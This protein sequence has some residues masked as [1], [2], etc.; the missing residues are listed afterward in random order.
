MNKVYITLAAA[1]A[2]HTLPLEAKVR[3]GSFTQHGYSCKQLSDR[4][5]EIGY[6]A[7]LFTRLD[8]ASEKD[9]LIITRAAELTLEK[10]FQYF[11]I[12]DNS[13]E[14]DYDPVRIMCYQGDAPR[15]G[16]DATAFLDR[17]NSE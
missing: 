11:I 12:V 1:I 5:F 3:E 7:G 10:G 6:K 9:K 17:I 15:G 4:S 2:L 16:I 8:C 13:G 14:Y